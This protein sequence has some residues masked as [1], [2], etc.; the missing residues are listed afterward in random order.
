[1]DFPLHQRINRRIIREETRLE[2]DPRFNDPWNEPEPEM[3]NPLPVPPQAQLWEIL[4]L[5][6]EIESEYVREAY[7]KLFG[8]FDIKKPKQWGA[9][10]DHVRRQLGKVQSVQINK[11]IAIEPKLYKEHMERLSAGY[12]PTRGDS[13]PII[14][15]LSSGMYIG[16]GNH[17]VANEHLKGKTTIQALVVDFRKEEK[18]HL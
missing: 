10:A 2:D 13:L 18:E 1:M 17:R 12:T 5:I 14:Y 7:Q 4:D 9:S 3:D 15:V 6:E 16:D 11:L 8:E